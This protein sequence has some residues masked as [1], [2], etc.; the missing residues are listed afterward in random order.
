ML[1]D[2]HYIFV[3]SRLYQAAD[4]NNDINISPSSAKLL[5]RN[6]MTF[7]ATW[8]CASEFLEMLS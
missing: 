5:N 6:N 8:G 1:H 4:H 2:Y 7:L 3:E